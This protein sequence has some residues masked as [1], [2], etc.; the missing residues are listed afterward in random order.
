MSKVSQFTGI[1]PAGNTPISKSTATQFSG[2]VYSTSY[3]DHSWSYTSTSSTSFVDVVNY[4]GSGVIDGLAAFCS[5]ADGTLELIMDGVTVDSSSTL[6]GL[7]VQVGGIITG[8]DSG[9]S[10][11]TGSLISCEEL[12]FKSSLQI[13]HKVTNGANTIATYYR[14]R[15][16]S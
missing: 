6:N 11:F 5:V 1:G 2:S 4:T 9:A 14:Y 12:V 13:R 7:I 15:K 3:I 16:T 10:N 8:F